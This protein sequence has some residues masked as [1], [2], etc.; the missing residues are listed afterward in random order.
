MNSV[1]SQMAA[2]VWQR[3]QAKQEPDDLL[4][5]VLLLLTEEAKDAALYHRLSK[6]ANKEKALIFE[7]LLRSSRQSL[8]ILRGI[9]YLLTGSHPTTATTQNNT[10]SLSLRLCYGNT[11]RRRIRYGQWCS[12][13]EY[14][15]AFV[16]L[17]TLTQQRCV[18]LLQL[19]GMP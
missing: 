10:S 1:D 5:E 7:S 16:Q 8:S 15:S 3:V 6:H 12:H 2:R 11:L 9:H 19:I 18:L 13:S 17:E 4:G 14:A